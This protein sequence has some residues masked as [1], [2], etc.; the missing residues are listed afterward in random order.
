MPTTESGRRCWT[1]EKRA[2]CSS[3]RSNSERRGR[4]SAAS[5][6]YAVWIWEKVSLF[7]RFRVTAA[8]NK[9]AISRHTITTIWPQRASRRARTPRCCAR[10]VL[11]RGGTHI[12]TLHVVSKNP[13][14]SP[15]NLHNNNNTHCAPGPQA[16]SRPTGTGFQHAAEQPNTRSHRYCTPDTI[17]YV[18]HPQQAERPPPRRHMR[19]GMPS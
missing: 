17:Q 15:Q 4:M 5:A 19:R 8:W 2:T 6:W 3:Q 7:P 13:P 14:Q 12:A 16:T 9:P 11:P 18:H 1:V 10:A